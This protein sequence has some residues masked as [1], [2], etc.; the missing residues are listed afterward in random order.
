[1]IS[2]EGRNIYLH[3]I[4]IDYLKHTEEYTDDNIKK[5]YKNIM[6]YK[7]HIILIKIIYQERIE[8]Y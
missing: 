3:E 5:N 8:F 2:N 4:L 7:T 1:M 6:I